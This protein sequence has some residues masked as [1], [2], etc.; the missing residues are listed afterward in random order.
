M[1]HVSLSAHAPLM[2]KI[3]PSENV[4]TFA[5]FYCVFERNIGLRFPERHPLGVKHI[6][7]MF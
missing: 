4:T 2:G 6:K 5:P 7:Y 1:E 3:L